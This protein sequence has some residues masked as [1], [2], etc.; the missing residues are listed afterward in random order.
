MKK[1]R[2]LVIA[3]FLF[4]MPS[5]LSTPSVAEASTPNFTSSIPSTDYIV[6]EIT[7]SPATGNQVLNYLKS[8][9]LRGNKIKR[10]KIIGHMTTDGNQG[11]YTLSDL[12]EL[13][14]DGT[15]DVPSYLAYHAS[16]L[17]KLTDTNNTIRSTG[18]Y[19]FAYSGLEEVELNSVTT[20]GTGA[21]RECLS[22]ISF[23]SST[24]Q[25]IENWAFSGC[26][27][28]TVF[29]ADNL[30]GQF[31]S[32]SLENTNID[33]LDLPNITA[34]SP[35]SPIKDLKNLRVLN[36]N[37]ISIAPRN[38]LNAIGSERLEYVA[39]KNVTNIEQPDVF[40][41]GNTNISTL[42]IH[43]SDKINFDSIDE[44]S[45][46]ANTVVAVP[47]APTEQSVNEGEPLTISAFTFKTA[48]TTNVAFQWFKNNVLLATTPSLLVTS[49]ALST[50]SGTITARLF[51]NNQATPANWPSSEEH[52]VNVLS[53]GAIGFE[54]VNPF[55]SFED[56]AISDRDILVKRKNSSTGIFIRDERFN[57]SSWEVH[58]KIRAPLT[59][60]NSERTLD[61]ALVYI[62]EKG[63]NTPLTNEA[64][65]VY[66]S[67]SKNNAT[68]IQWEQNQGILLNIASQQAFVGQF[69]TE[70][71]WE[72]VLAP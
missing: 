4:M 52:I 58:A 47:K 49:E 72:L 26:T 39:I 37:G 65:P 1:Y 24:L 45:L 14:L 57:K 10:L 23:K 3:L 59:N 51:V 55:F 42:L 28:L 17:K 53:A 8:M 44:T 38:F 9:D 63:N 7:G 36:L 34:V 35:W 32:S 27:L 56:F 46:H 68:E 12:E 19:S 60:L 20:L 43:V 50:H 15:A 41:T 61:S 31:V 5:I 48:P 18:M 66:K 69:S 6:L 21:F 2:L 16:N 40:A 29:E 64:L 11:V 67:N 70:I 30:S 54:V 33:T 22:L 25:K 13:E 62:D 71:Q